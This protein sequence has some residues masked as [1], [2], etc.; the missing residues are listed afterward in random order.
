MEASASF[1]VAWASGKG[2]GGGAVGCFE[3]LLP[4]G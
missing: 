3:D 1:S 4:Q 2:G